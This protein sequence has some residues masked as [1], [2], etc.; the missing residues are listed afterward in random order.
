MSP[1]VLPCSAFRPCANISNMRLRATAISVLF[2]V[3]AFAQPAT[4]G[5]FSDQGVF[6]L[7]ENEERIARLSFQWKPDGSF[8]GRLAVSLAGQTERADMTLAPDAAGRWIKA[9]VDSSTGIRVFERNGAQF[10]I[11]SPRMKGHG[12][13]DEEMLTFNTSM[14]PLISQALRSYDQARGGKQSFQVMVLDKD[15]AKAALTVERQGAIART[16]GGRNLQLTRWLYAPPEREYHVLADADGKVY[17]VSGAATGGG[18]TPDK[19]VFVR[20]GFEELRDLP[21]E[22][23]PISLPKFDVDVKPGVQI[24]MRD[25]VKLSTDLYL[26]AD[27]RSPSPAAPGKSPVVLIR[28]PYRKEMEELQGRFYARRGYVVAIQDVRGRFASEGQWEPFI[29]EPRDGYD[30]I[31]WLARRPWSTGKV[32]MIGASYLGWVQWLAASLRP[33]HLAAMIPNVSPPDPFHNLPY[34][35]G[36]FGLALTLR[37][38]ALVESN[39]TGELSNERVEEVNSKIQPEVLNALPVIGLDKAVTGRE[40]PYWRNWVMHPTPDRYWAAAMFAGSLK[41]LTVPVF[42]QSGWF[43]GDSIG[44]KL[45]YLRM[46]AFGRRNQ[47]LTLGPWEHSDT[48]SRI[49]A[50][51]DFGPAAIIDLQ[52]DYLRWFD[53]WLKGMD[54]GVMQEPLVSMFVM[55]ANQWIHGPTYPLPETRFEKLYLSSGGHANTSKGDGK[56]SFHAPDAAQPQDRYI[57]DPGDPRPETDFDP[58]QRDKFDAE[59]QDI[60]VFTSEPFD[61][62][63]TIAGPVSAVL[64]AATSARDTDWYVHLLDVDEKGNSSILWAN[65][66]G[67]HVRARYRQSLAKSELLVPGKV[68]KYTLDLWHTAVR[69]PPGHRLR[70]EVASACFPLFDRNLNTGGNNETESRYISAHQTIYHDAQH[71]SYV[72]LPVVP[73]AGF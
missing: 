34:D 58:S 67:G 8:D 59:R 36:V 19:G 24:P 56:L 43:D 64:Y 60:L 16:A 21:H 10:Q 37:W 6:F 18:A 7:Y 57:Y 32:G 53:H 55:G 65:D 25:G 33:P 63:Y 17:L 20:E 72:L 22:T 44:S 23:G 26:P 9:V 11:S 54:N 61:Q 12:T 51:R 5:G 13:M 4:L 27:P 31:E 29:H 39:A 47:K 15:L 28:T 73:A 62:P 45:N 41:N 38:T 66:S 49:A 48:A 46:A 52:R 35:N 40:L 70:V 71:P 50:N 42:H 3:R 69:I 2:A 1:A 14:P 68:Y 30:T